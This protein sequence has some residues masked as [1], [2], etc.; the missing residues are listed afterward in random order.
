MIYARDTESLQQTVLEVEG[1]KEVCQRLY[2]FSFAAVTN[3][4]KKGA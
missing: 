1:D 3:C 4:Y 2:Q